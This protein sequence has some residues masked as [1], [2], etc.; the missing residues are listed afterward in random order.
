MAQQ[1]DRLQQE[2]V[3]FIR[4]QQ[5]YFVATA[6]RDGHVNLSPKGQDS[7]RTQVYV[8][9]TACNEYRLPVW[10]EELISWNVFN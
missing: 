8:L 3:E 4:A 1:F 7:L 6:A 10:G 5:M 2:H 9:I